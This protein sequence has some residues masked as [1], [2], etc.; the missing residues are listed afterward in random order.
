MSDNQGVVGHSNKAA[1][2]EWAIVS[3]EQYPAIMLAFTIC[4]KQRT[5]RYKVLQGVYKAKTEISWLIPIDVYEYLLV[6]GWFDDQDSVLLLGTMQRCGATTGRK[7]RLRHL[8][9]RPD[10]DIGLFMETLI[11]P[12]IEMDHTYDPMNGTWFHTV[13]MPKATRGKR[14][15]K[16]SAAEHYAHELAYK[17]SRVASPVLA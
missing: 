6:E 17:A 2:E 16:F 15:S 4:L 14:L 1:Q 13:P 12:T 8:D 5:E 11:K 7:A 9:G 3:V 10:T